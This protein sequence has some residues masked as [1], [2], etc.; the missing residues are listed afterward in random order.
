MAY[1][2]RTVFC[3]LLLL[4]F[5]NDLYSQSYTS[6]FTGDVADV[7]TTTQKGTVLMGGA[8]ENDNAMKWFLQHSGGGDIVV[9]RASGSNGYNNYLYSTLGIPVNSVESIVCNNASA[10]YDPYVIQQVANAEALWFAGGDQ[11]NYISYWNNTPLDSVF[12]YLINVKHIPVGGTSAGM[13]IMGHIV[14]TAQNGSVSSA[15]ALNDP[16]NSAV[17]LLKDDFI[18]NPWLNNVITDT[19]YD[20]PDR[21]GRHIS[22]LARISRD[23]GVPAFGI[24]C[25]EYTAVCIDSNGLAS[26]YGNYPSSND[27]A[28]FLQTNCVQPTI[29]ETCLAGEPLNWVRNQQAVKVYKVAGTQNG[30]N[31]FQLSN[32]KTG[33]GGTW[34]NWYVTDG[35]LNVTDNVAAPACTVANVNAGNVNICSP[36]TSGIVLVADITGP[37]YQWQLNTGSGFTNISNN[38]NYSGVVT[39]TLSLNSIPS[40]WY[41]YKYRCVVNGNNSSEATLIFSNTWTGLASTAWEDPGNWKCNT[42]PDAY[43]D[44]YLNAGSIVTLNSNVSCRSLHLIST[45]NFTIHSSFTLTTT[46]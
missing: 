7:V 13:A 25:E 27:Y 42:L 34:Q 35:T 4:V 10:S 12:N 15:T 33:V 41:G 5:F 46:H 43:T 40:S 38:S 28:Y 29:P 6:Y 44:V 8:T 30:A 2:L 16:Y 9:L 37:N 36:S 14:F 18:S 26:V 1:S 24:A 21:R 22:F 32:W 19:H 31:T 23:F 20:N 45:A 17:T 11:W 3:T 39:N